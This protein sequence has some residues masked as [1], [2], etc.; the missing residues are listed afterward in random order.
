MSQEMQKSFPG[1]T[2][3]LEVFI[4]GALCVAY[5]GQCLTSESLGGRS[6]NRGVCAQACRLPYSLIADGQQVPLEGRHY[7]LS[8][9]DLSGIEL[10]PELGQ[11]GVKTLK[12]EGRLKSPEYVASI[13]RIYRKALDSIWIEEPQSAP[14]QV[15]KLIAGESKY[16]LEM[17]FSRGLYSGWLR[18]VDNRALVHARFGKKRG[19]LLGKIARAENNQVGLKLEAPLKPGDGIVF[20]AGQPDQE[21]QGGRVYGVMKREGWTGL[22]LDMTISTFPKWLQGSLSGRLM[23]LSLASESGKPLRLNV[24]C[25]SALFLS[26]FSDGQGK[27]CVLQPGTRE[28]WRWSSVPLNCWSTRKSMDY[29]RQF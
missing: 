2:I 26:R 8:P 12:I 9:Q 15:A 16:E 22:N 27:H 28:V 6:A 24:L 13:T 17:A 20:D 7:L 21:E 29:R 14:S 4:H 10:L 11:A 18:G 25:F 23:I 5:S 1:S 19:V 3:P